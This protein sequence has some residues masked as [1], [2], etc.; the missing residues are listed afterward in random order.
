MRLLIFL[1]L[2]ATPLLAQETTPDYRFTTSYGLSGLTGED[3]LN[4]GIFT[5]INLDRIRPIG[6][7]TTLTL[8][9]G[10]DYANYE[11]GTENEP[12]DFPFGLKVIT[13]SFNETYEFNPLHA[14]LRLG[15]EQRFGRFSVRALLLPT[16]RVYDRITSNSA[17][18]FDVTGRPDQFSSQKVRPE[19]RFTST[20]GSN[21]ELRYNSPFQL[22]AAVEIDFSIG[23]RYAIGMGFRT[24]LTK[25]RLYNYVT[26]S[27]FPS[28]PDPLCVID[29][30]P[31]FIEYEASS[32]NA[33][34]SSG[35]LTLRVAL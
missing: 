5:S 9:M 26:E 16:L 1:A 25:Y 23:K 11:N 24:G 10:L 4:K 30:C 13:F 19:E 35:Y 3:A 15:A 12:C 18:N 7:K 31:T 32:V 33:R 6:P 22:Q 8:G 34:T 2:L 17:I 29:G 28:I 27:Q 14:T 21:R 20:D